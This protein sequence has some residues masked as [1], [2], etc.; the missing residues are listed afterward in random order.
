MIYKN[1]KDRK[2]DRYFL[3]EDGCD[4]S[5]LICITFLGKIKLNKTTT[6]LST[7]V[8]EATVTKK[9]I[10]NQ[11]KTINQTK[12]DKFWNQ[13]ISRKCGRNNHF[14]IPDSSETLNPKKAWR[15]NP[16]CKQFY[17]MQYF[18]WYFSFAKKAKQKEDSEVKQDTEFFVNFWDWKQL[19]WLR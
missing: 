6:L 4:L 11:T 10:S 16:C 14:G 19:K 13:T 2:H 17:F 9:N 12:P 5:N 1:V 18:I 8:L 3:I 15:H 7:V